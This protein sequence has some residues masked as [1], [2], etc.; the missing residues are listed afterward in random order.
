MKELARPHRQASVIHTLVVE[1]T[2]HAI[3]PTGHPATARFEEREF[4][5]R[6]PIAYTAHDQ[7]GSSS[8][9]LEGMRDAMAHGAAGGEAVHRE[10]G[11]SALGTAMNS[12]REAHL[13]GFVPE[14]FISGIM[15]HASV[16]GIRAN[17]ART[18]AEVLRRET[19][20][21]DGS[22]DGLHR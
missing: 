22:I 19:H 11:L 9:H 16:V 1:M 14:R 21:V 4:Q 7:A 13:L 17:E 2:I 8:H 3:E 12:H 20:L 18:K 10:S 6:M 15:Q 5:P